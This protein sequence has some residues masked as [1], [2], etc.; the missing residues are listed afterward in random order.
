[1]KDDAISKRTGTAPSFWRCIGRELRDGLYEAAFEIAWRAALLAVGTATLMVFWA[2]ASS[3][4][5]R[6]SSY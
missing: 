6:L 2:W 3:R 5:P 4:R 1:M